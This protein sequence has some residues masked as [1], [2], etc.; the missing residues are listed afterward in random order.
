MDELAAAGGAGW[1]KFNWLPRG[2]WSDRPHPS[3][4]FR[5]PLPPS[6]C[7][8]LC[9]CLSVSVSAPG[10]ASRMRLRHDASTPNPS[11]SH[12]HAAVAGFSAQLARAL[13]TL[14]TRVAAF[15]RASCCLLACL[16]CC[17]PVPHPPLSFLAS[18]YVLAH[19]LLCPS[20][21]PLSYLRRPHVHVLTCERARARMRAR[22]CV[23][24]DACMCA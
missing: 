21:L 2:A 8:C 10:A 12:G 9:L 4:A 16:L 17:R 15:S 11:C 23:C 18:S 6:L 19:I 1:H 3:T 5:S 24:M 22:G 7:L 20:Y 14:G 13:Q